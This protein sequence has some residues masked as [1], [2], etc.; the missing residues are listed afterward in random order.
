[1]HEMSVATEICRIAERHAAGHPELVTTVGVQLGEKVG[2]EPANLA[3]CLDVLLTQPP[4]AG[5]RATFTTIPGDDMRV[6][7]VEIDD[8]AEG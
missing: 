2:L 1:M 3:F 8:D 6:D 7:Y 4:F 5:A